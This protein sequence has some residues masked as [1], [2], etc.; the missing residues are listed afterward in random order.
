MSEQPTTEELRSRWAAALKEKREALGWSQRRLAL[1]A[2]VSN[3]TVNELERGEHSGSDQTRIALARA[4]KCE[5]HE[6]FA[7]PTLTEE[8][9]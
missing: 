7:Y 5:V 3:V 2:G 1:A 8:A 9:S 4:L 6:L